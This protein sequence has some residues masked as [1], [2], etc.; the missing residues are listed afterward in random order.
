MLMLQIYSQSEAPEGVDEITRVIPLPFGYTSYPVPKT[1]K[2]H[3]S[4]MYVIE[5]VD[6]KDRQ[7][8]L[9]IREQDSAYVL[10]EQG[11][12]IQTIFKPI[13]ASF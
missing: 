1:G 8:E 5:T 3:Q 2:Y 4:V 13:K 9:L 7:I 10:N 6:I 12:T 11:K